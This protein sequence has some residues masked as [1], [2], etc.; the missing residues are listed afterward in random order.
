MRQIKAVNR[1]TGVPLLRAPKD[2]LAEALTDAMKTLSDDTWLYWVMKES[3]TISKFD[4]LETIDPLEPKVKG[5][6]AHASGKVD[7][8]KTNVTT[9]RFHEPRSFAF[10]IEYKSDKDHLG[11]PDLKVIQASFNPVNV[12]DLMMFD[13][14]TLIPPP[15]KAQVKASEKPLA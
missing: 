9:D 11:L 14:Q 15:Q 6:H 8:G 7:L 5:W 1:K 13:D 2:L 4:S 12:G 10:T 3:I